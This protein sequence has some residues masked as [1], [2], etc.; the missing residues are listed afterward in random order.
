MSSLPYSILL[1]E[2]EEILPQLS[3]QEHQKFCKSLLK[4]YQS[5]KKRN[6]NEKSD[7]NKL[8]I[9]EEYFKTQKKQK[10]EEILKWFENLSEYEKIKICTIKNKWLVNILIQLYIIYNT[11]D[12]CYIRPNSPMEDLFQPQ[13]NFSHEDED[14][15]NNI[16]NNNNYQ[17]YNR[18]KLLVNDLKF[19]ENFFSIHYPSNNNMFNK[20]ETEKRDKEKKLIDNVKLLSLEEN[21]IIDTLTLSKDLIVNNKEMKD[22]LL[23]FSKNEC[24]QDWLLPIKLNNIY[25][26]VLPSW[27]HNNKTLNLFQL[28]IGYIEQQILLNYEFFYYSK[29]LY[30][31]SYNN[32]IIDLYEENIKLVSFVK[33]N[34]SFHDNND[35]INKKE[36]ISLMEIREIVRDIKKSTNYEKKISELQKIYNY[37]YNNEFNPG[38]RRCI[39]NMNFDKQMYEDLYKESM[40]GGVTGIAKV[41][42]HITFMQFQDII[43]ARDNLFTALRKKIANN[44]LQKIMDELTSGD[45]NSGNSNKKKNKNKK[46][47]K[48]N[49]NSGNKTNKEEENNN[50]IKNINIEDKKDSENNLKE[51]ENN[52]DKINEFR[53]E[54]NINI[55][56]KKNDGK[57]INLVNKEKENK[58]FE[59]KFKEKIINLEN[60]KNDNLTDLIISNTFPEKEDEKKEIINLEKKKKTKDFFLYP[61]NNKKKNKKK[62]NLQCLSA[63][64][65]IE[66]KKILIEDKK[67]IKN[68]S[69]SLERNK[70]KNKNIFNITKINLKIEPKAQENNFGNVK[71]PS[72]L[73]AQHQS[74]SFLKKVEESNNDINI[75]KE[76][77]SNSKLKNN[78]NT[79]ITFEDQK[80]NE[81]DN[82]NNDINETYNNN[83]NNINNSK[84]TNNL[85]NNYSNISIISTPYT[86]YAPSEK[87]FD[88]LTKEISNYILITNKNIGNLKDIYLK[89]LTDLENLITNGLESKYEIKFGHYGSHFTNLSIEG[90][91]LDILINYKPKNI[92]NNNDFNKDILSILNN[93][94]T[95]FDSI[96]PILTASVPVIKLQIDIKNE[97][98]NL[99]LNY[100]SYFE[101]QNELQKMNIDLTFT[102]NEQEFQ[103]SHQIVTYINQSLI[104]FPMIKPLLLILKR[105]FKIMKM[106]KS[107][108]GGLSSYSLYL[109]IYAFFKKF[110][111]SNSSS[112]K[113]L[114]SFL[115]FFS[116]FE[117]HKY[118]IDIDHINIYFLQNNY[119]SNSF[120][121]E[122]ETKKNEINIIDPLTKLNVAKSSFKVVEIQNTFRNAYDFLRTEGCYYDYAILA[123]KTGYENN[124]FSLKSNF[125]FD[126]ASDFKTI[127]KLFALNKNGFFFN[128]FSN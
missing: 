49:K 89:Y 33:E 4:F 40:N 82:I 19:Y 6:S 48:K 70:E 110:P 36:F 38:N 30:D 88:L 7:K 26:F 103:H 97:I 118:G 104:S 14:I 50:T 61:I 84:E 101:D 13:K 83:T 78:K 42:D 72:Y 1:T 58:D 64:K 62:K 5:Y 44:Q 119:I 2:N 47:K 18:N 3:I 60:I 120:D 37:A 117:F 54:D 121:F 53:L 96:T 92:E 77:N 100:M 73:E 10:Q 22:F 24:F 16:M 93:N 126:N 115:A 69:P 11:Y 68:K 57:I 67:E 128:F 43:N 102:Q 80:I 125:E 34:Y 127:K 52:F 55:E 59:L 113:A 25:N 41:I 98:N 20:S 29:K 95:K 32:K 122:E 51:S 35:D 75:S 124:Y 90:S 123:N 85:E 87:F 8:K 56:N 9:E 65:K 45:F 74:F 46:K 107:F 39:L 106:N 15:A 112:G 21:N 17:Y 94:S 105:Y 31:F 91:D 86:P 109:L 76:I 63:K 71:S 27:M 116:F 111:T 12:S 23:F 108:H 99:N 79:N 66:N 114:Y 81:N 28:I